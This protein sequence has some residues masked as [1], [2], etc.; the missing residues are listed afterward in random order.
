MNLTKRIMGRSVAVAVVGMG[1]LAAVGCDR[2]DRTSLDHDRNGNPVVVD[3]SPTGDTNGR[4]VNNDNLGTTTV[5]GANIG[6][7]ANQTA[8]EKIVAARCARETTC[9]NVGANKQYDSATA[10]T[11]KIRSSMKDDLNAK[12]CPNGADQKELDE[13][14][15]SIRKEECNNP[16][17]S[18]SRLAACRTSD[19]CLKT[20]A[21]NR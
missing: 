19:I 14:L 13:C 6:S 3:R 2:T 11:S 12:D 20:A 21:P 17:D 10:C 18:I 9:N 15:E 5:T 4:T 16:I 8:I 7:V 1:V